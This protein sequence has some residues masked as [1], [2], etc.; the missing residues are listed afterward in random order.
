MTSRRDFKGAASKYAPID[1]GGGYG[2]HRTNNPFYDPEFE[3]PENEEIWAIT[4]GD[5]NNSYYVGQPSREDLETA[6]KIAMEDGLTGNAGE[7]LF[8]KIMDG[9]YERPVATAP[10]SGS[11]FPETL[12]DGFDHN[13]S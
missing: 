5:S 8:G 10:S 4:L 2:A 13:R 1:L 6:L 7:H 12:F 9:T 3:G 11:P